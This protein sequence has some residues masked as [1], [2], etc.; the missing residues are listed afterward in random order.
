MGNSLAV[1]IPAAYAKAIGAREHGKAELSIE[2]GRLVLRP[3]S[4]VD[5]YDLD[6][7]LAE[8]TDGNRHDEIETGPPVAAEYG[9][10]P[11]KSE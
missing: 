7:L 8:I 1:R 4:E 5:H 6:A 11:G 10:A 3:V 2:D 9:A